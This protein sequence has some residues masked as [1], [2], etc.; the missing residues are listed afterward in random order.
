MVDKSQLE[1]QIETLRLKMYLAL[2]EGK[3]Y[4]EIVNISKELDKL[5]NTFDKK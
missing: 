1:R 5:L 4:K 2:Q 3:S